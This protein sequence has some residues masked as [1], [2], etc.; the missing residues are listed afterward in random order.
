[1][2]DHELSTIFSAED[3][4]RVFVDFRQIG[5]GSFGAVYYARNQVTGEVVAIKELKVD[6]KRKKCEEEWNDI[7]REIK[8]LRTVFH[9]NCVLS[10]GCYMKDQ[11]PW[12]K[13]HN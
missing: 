7:V 3:P 4:T 10:K 11:T 1:M 9:P 2:M 8:L 6:T 13:T 12:V 5:C